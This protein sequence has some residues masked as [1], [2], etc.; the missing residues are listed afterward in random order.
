MICLG[1][2][3]NTAAVIVGGIMGMLFGKL[4]K[5][6]HRGTLNM[7]CG[8][9][10]LFIGISGALQGMLTA[11]EGGVISGSHSVLVVVCLVL[12]AVVGEIINLE[13]GFERFGVWLRNKTGNAGDGNFVNGFVT[14]SL[15]VCIGAMA[16]VGSIQD[17]INRDPSILITKSVLDL[18]IILV[19]A[20]AMG[21]GCIFSALPI[22]LLEGG[23]TLLASLIKPIMTD[24][25]LSYLSL[26]GSVLIFCVG[27]NLV[28]GKKI[29][30][31]NFLPAIL[32]AVAA[33]FLPVSL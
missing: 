26:V 9:S 2:L 22:L 3:I 27:V 19:M 21:K 20:G 17:G 31:A 10:T 14:A 28:W 30:V 24:L 16:V 11:G 5:E 18:I 6:R 25:A 8:V 12:G 15:T 1:A 32:F 4:L 13:D 29:R 33:A 23:I 7:A